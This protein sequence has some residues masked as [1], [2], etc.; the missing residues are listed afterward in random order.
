MITTPY[1]SGLSTRVDDGGHRAVALMESTALRRSKSVSASPEMITKARRTATARPASRCPRCPGVSPRPCSASGRQTR[2]R[3][4][5]GLNLVGQ[6]VK[7]G[8]DVGEA[9][10]DQQLDDVLHDRLV[11]DGRR[12]GTVTGEGTQTA[13]SPPAMTTAF[14]LRS[15]PTK[16]ASGA[17]RQV[18]FRPVFDPAAGWL[19][20]ETCRNQGECPLVRTPAQCAAAQVRTGRLEP[21]RGHSPCP[22]RPRDAPSIPRARSEAAPGAPRGGALPGVSAT[23]LLCM[24][25]RSRAARIGAPSDDEGLPCR[26]VDSRHWHPRAATAAS[27]CARTG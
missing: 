24:E 12:L 4:K 15:F 22:A 6:V 20:V 19:G 13:S 7:R 17:R 10:A 25:F 21:W 5:I 23:D 1:S 11:D 16:R 18:L 2:T 9:R 27:G 26:R 14:I 3:L 8:D